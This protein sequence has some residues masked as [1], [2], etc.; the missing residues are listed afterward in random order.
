MSFPVRGR[1]ASVDSLGGVSEHKGDDDSPLTIPFAFDEAGDP[2]RA[3]PFWSLV[4]LDPDTGS[5]QAIIKAADEGDFEAMSSLLTSDVKISS[6]DRG[7]ILIS[8]VASGK[9]DVVYRALES[10]KEPIPPEYM[11]V[12]VVCTAIGNY[13]HI[14][15][16]LLSRDCPIPEDNLLEAFEKAVKAKN[17]KIAKLLLVDGKIKM[18]D[19]LRGE[20]AFLAVQS[21]DIMLLQFLLPPGIKL[22]YKDRRDAI[23]EAIAYPN[24]EILRFLLPLTTAIFCSDMGGLEEGAVS[25]HLIGHS[26]V[27]SIEHRNLEALKYLLKFKIT[28]SDKHRTQAIESAIKKP[29]KRLCSKKE[30]VQSIGLEMV[31][32]LSK[33]GGS[34]SFNYLGLALTLGAKHNNIAVLNYLLSKAPSEDDKRTAFQVAMDNANVEAVFCLRS[35]REEYLEAFSFFQSAGIE[36]PEEY[37][38]QAAI[39]LSEQV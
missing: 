32:L 28:L 1:P 35:K 10:A 23:H 12:A 38:V 21:Q 25:D 9:I 36:I 13:F 5:V 6:T 15:Q 37:Q 22:S 19:D 20:A 26:I 33:V 2:S 7:K 17:L 18:S 31:K 39:F 27:L 34:D 24:V 3:S 14:L 29:E 16:A 4:D 30:E 11:G 8:A